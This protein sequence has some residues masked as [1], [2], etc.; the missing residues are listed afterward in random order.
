MLNPPLYC[1]RARYP[2]S[3]PANAVGRLHESE[4]PIR[5]FMT[6]HQLEVQ[7]ASR[8]AR[9]W[10]RCCSSRFVMIHQTHRCS[11]TNLHDEPSTGVI[12]VAGAPSHFLLPPSPHAVPR[13]HSSPP[14]PHAVPREHS[15][16]ELKPLHS[17]D[18]YVLPFS[19]LSRVCTSPRLATRDSRQK[20]VH[21]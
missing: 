19:P 13:E 8:L 7:L 15:R 2:M 18:S 20:Y 9:R 17:L 11:H 12:C 14:S 10:G 5:I 6:G 16:Q 4:R 1:C 3:A 21:P